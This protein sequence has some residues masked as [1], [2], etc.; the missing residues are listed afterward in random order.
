MKVTSTTNWGAGAND[1]RWI[2]EPFRNK[3]VF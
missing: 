1:L 3:G 2:I